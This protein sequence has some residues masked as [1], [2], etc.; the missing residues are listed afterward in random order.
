MLRLYAQAHNFHQSKIKQPLHIIM[1]MNPCSFN[2]LTG[3]SYLQH[4]V[5]SPLIT[6]HQAIALRCLHSLKTLLL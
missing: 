2:F 1:E 6:R 4:N 3:L 5:P